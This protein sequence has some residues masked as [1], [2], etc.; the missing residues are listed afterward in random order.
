MTHSPSSIP[1]FQAEP[2]SLAAVASASVLVADFANADSSGKL[3][4]IGGALQYISRVQ[5]P[6]FGVGLPPMTV[7]VII[8]VPA[9]YGQ[10]DFSLVLT[11]RDGA[12][13]PV[14][15]P[16]QAPG[17]SQAM[18][19]SQ[20]ANARRGPEQPTGILGRV[21]LVMS[22]ATGIPLQP[23]EAYYWELEINGHTD[24]N[25]RASFYVYPDPP[26]PIIG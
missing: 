7:V 9:E 5:M 19:I 18:R 24:R 8:D 26:Q 20:I 10:T 11:L 25:W 17:E 3:N 4:M 1:G 16:A 2:D 22:L 23:G 13:K 15:V 21:Q 6:G 14:Q 12:G